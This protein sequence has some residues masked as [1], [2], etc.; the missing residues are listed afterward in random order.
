M[1]KKVNPIGNRKNRNTMP[2]NNIN[3]IANNSIRT[4]R[5]QNQSSKNNNNGND[6]SEEEMGLI[7]K[8]TNPTNSLSRHPKTIF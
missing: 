2:N 5:N 6:S 4:N 1:I 8:K 3:R 7:P